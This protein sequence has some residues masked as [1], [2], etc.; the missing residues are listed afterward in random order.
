MKTISLPF[1]QLLYIC[2]ICGYQSQDRKFIEQC[3]GTLVTIPRCSI[4]EEIE[5]EGEQYRVYDLHYSRPGEIMPNRSGLEHPKTHTLCITLKQYCALT[6][7]GEV[8]RAWNPEDKSSWEVRM[9]YDVFLERKEE[10]NR[11]LKV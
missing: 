6:E 8:R 10:W 1:G 3:E 9:T 5:F 2:E 7:Q 11:E 4:S